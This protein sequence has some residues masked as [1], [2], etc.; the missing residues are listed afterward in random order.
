MTRV[1]D[2]DRIALDTL[3]VDYRGRQLSPGKRREV[4]ANLIAVLTGAQSVQEILS[5]RR[6]VLARSG[7]ASG[8]EMPPTV[9]A[10]RNDLSDTLTVIETEG[11]DA[12]G[13]LYRVSEALSRLGWD[14]R[15]ARVSNWRNEARASFYVAGA[16]H[17]SEAEARSALAQVLPT[18]EGDASA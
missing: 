2:R 1:T 15:S 16:R 14:I 10:I 7:K 18:T 3:W 4:S 9:R 13:T 11:Q 17:L 5:R 6:T 8:A 12:R